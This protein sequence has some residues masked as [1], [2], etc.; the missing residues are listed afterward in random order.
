MD[1]LSKV[2][3]GIQCTPVEFFVCKAAWL[4]FTVVN[5]GRPTPKTPRFCYTVICESHR[6]STTKRSG[7]EENTVGGGTA[8]SSALDLDESDIIQVLSS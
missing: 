6:T 7:V 1:S 4:K 5:A 2:K 3:E 8:V